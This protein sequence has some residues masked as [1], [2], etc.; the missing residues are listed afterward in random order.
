MPAFRDKIRGRLH[1]VDKRKLFYTVEQ[2]ALKFRSYIGV[3]TL[4]SL[5]TGV[6]CAAWALVVG[7]DLA[8]RWSGACS[9]SC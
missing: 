2:V 5:I 7:L 3:T 8:L 4:T 1:D 6:A 9:T